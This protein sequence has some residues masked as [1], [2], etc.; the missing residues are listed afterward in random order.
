MAFNRNGNTDRVKVLIDTNALLMPVQ[1]KIDIF[2]EIRE[3]LGNCRIIT[4]DEVMNELKGI[5]KG[6]GKDA[7]A[8]RFGTLLASKIDIVPSGSEAPTVDERIVEYALNNNCLVV[9]NDRALRE[10]LLSK[11]I[12]VLSMRNQKK[13]ELRRG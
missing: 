10:R 4:I 8:A 9:T 12:G 7:S 11:D 6:S 1:F 2:E 13:L 3:I 5:A